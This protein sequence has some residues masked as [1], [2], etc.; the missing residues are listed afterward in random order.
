MISSK[1]NVAKEVEAMIGSAVRV[2]GG[3]SKTVRCKL[4]VMNATM[5]PT[6]V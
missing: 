2:I 6:L 3:M 5:L 1:G 4:K